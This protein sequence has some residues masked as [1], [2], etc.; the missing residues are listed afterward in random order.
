MIWFA[1]KSAIVV[2][3][4]LLV[5]AATV[6][7]V[8]L[9]A[10]PSS[11]PLSLPIIAER[12]LRWLA[13]AAIG[14]FGSSRSQPDPIG[15]LLADRLAVTLPL[16]LIAAAMAIAFGI[17]VGILAGR[18]GTSAGRA[19]SGVAKLVRTIPE[20]WAGL[21]LILV[22][23]SLLHILP[24]GGF[25]AWSSS[26]LLSLSSLILPA[27]ALAMPTGA[28][29][30]ADVGAAFAS[31]RGAAYLR[32]AE[33]RGLTADEA[34]RRHGLRN[35]RAAVLD[36]AGRR[37]GQLVAGSVVVESVF[38]LPGLGRLLLDAAQARDATLMGGVVLAFLLGLAIARFLVQLARGYL[39]PRL[40]R[41]AIT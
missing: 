24:S 18:Q 8:L 39:D 29:I 2:M 12:Y 38:Y 27:L 17:S 16:V 14:D 1:A 22:G 41:R 25:I 34:M 6:F 4:R 3:F 5:A 10:M 21:L 31:A 40:L 13:G 30:A 33:A 23:S 9:P 7:L 28:A 15:P 37:V 36:R 35:I 26:P 20:L 32:A 11:E 19:L